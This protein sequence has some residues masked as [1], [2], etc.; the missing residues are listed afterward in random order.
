[1]KTIKHLLLIF[2]ILPLISLSQHTLSGRFEPAKD[3]NYVFLYKP[4]L[5]TPE[6]VQ[7]QKIDSLGKFKMELDSTVTS[8]VYK[9]IYGIPVEEN[10]FEIIY[11]A[12][13]SIDFTFYKDSTIT[14]HKSN[15]NKLWQSYMKSM[16]LVN[17]AISNFYLQEK[18]LKTGFES[19]FKTLKETQ[20]S[21]E[22]SAQGTLAKKFIVA[23]RPYIPESF[24]D[25][26]TYSRKLKAN[27]LKHIDYN[28]PILQKSSFLIKR[29][30]NYVFD[31]IEKPTSNT[32]IKLVNEVVQ[33]FG[34]STDP[35]VKEQI[36][37]T[38][39]KRYLE[40][41]ND[42]LVK[43]IG[44]KY[45]IKLAKETGNQKLKIIVTGEVNTSIGSKAPNFEINYTKDIRTLYDLVTHDNYLLIFWSSTCGH[46]LTELPQ[47]HKKLKA[48]PNIKVIAF[49]IENDTATWS[50]EKE[51][52]PDFIH[53][54]GLGKWT[55]K[56]AEI[57]G[58]K[59]TPS[60]FLLD[61]DKKIIAKPF[62]LSDV[63]ADL[64]SL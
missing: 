44:E 30:E 45:L 61:D 13:E 7:S 3:F 64:K 43:Y 51:K 29:V 37:S 16:G 23:N 22:L 47:I 28:D 62:S 63:L 49:G 1:M 26:G 55:N 40:E 39:W 2:G 36:L 10:N 50:P 17:Q 4:T 6:F 25:V 33:S 12:K 48:Y 32:S 24:Q 54:I 38:I 42:A 34:D 18:K 9:V 56:I 46:C 52:M 31:M 58:I 5:E 59:G 60:Y 20:E 21:Y 19:I 8:G 41:K 57:Y 14:Y 11:N 35:K 53:T 27:Y 15:E